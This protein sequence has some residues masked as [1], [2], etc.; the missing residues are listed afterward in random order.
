MKPQMQQNS[1]L[2]GEFTLYHFN[3]VPVV[4][5]PSFFP[6]PILLSGFLAWLAGKSKPERSL[7]QRIGTGIVAMPVALIAD[8]GHAMGH[9]FSARLADAPMDE[10]FLSSGMPRTLYQNNDF[11]PKTHI[12][13]SLGGPV[14]SLICSTLSLVW[15]RRSSKRLDQP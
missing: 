5:Q 13:R 14:F 8:V 3:G 11:P 2:P 15:W 12:L 10:I 9:T 7:A 1:N 6:L 4:A